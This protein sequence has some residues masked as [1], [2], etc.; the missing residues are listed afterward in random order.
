MSRPNPFD[1][2]A[3]WVKAK[4]FMNW[5]MDDDVDRTFQ[6]RALWA[7]L[8]FELLAKSAL[9]HHSPLLVAE[10]SEDGM[11][12]LAASGL[13]DRDTRGKS[14]RAKTV[15]TRC[16]RAFKPFDLTKASVIADARNEFLHGTQAV[17]SPIPEA[18]WWADFWGQAIILITAQD[19]NLEDLVGPSRVDAVNEHLERNKRNL[20]ERVEMLMGRAAQ[21]YA[22][23]ERGDLP[24]RL[25]SQL[26]AK[27]ERSAGLSYSDIVDCPACG[28]RG[29]LEGEEVVDTQVVYE[30]VGEEDFEPTVTATVG[31]DYFSCEHCGLVLEGVELLERAGLP[32]DFPTETDG[33][34]LWEEEYGND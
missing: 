12:L 1:Y 10:P 23:H 29:W 9:S 3:F 34:H 22:L 30:Q 20:D 16:S 15:F 32:V 13:V 19:R 8:A 33:N 14:A 27:L 11:N 18:A 2:E 6:E 25:H 24:A 7:A 21:R 28:N 26:S 4:L 5:A 31:A 17:I